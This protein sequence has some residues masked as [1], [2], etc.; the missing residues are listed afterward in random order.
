KQHHMTKFIFDEV[1]IEEIENP[2]KL[3]SSIKDLLN[4][5]ELLI[6]AP[7]Q[8]K[9][10]KI[11]KILTNPT[12]EQAS[13]LKNIR[14]FRFYKD[15]DEKKQLKQFLEIIRKPDNPLPELRSL[16]L[17]N[18]E[19]DC[20]LTLTKENVPTQITEL[21]FGN[22]YGTVKLSGL[23]QVKKVSTGTIV[24]E[25]I[26]ENLENLTEICIKNQQD[27]TPKN[28]KLVLTNLLKFKTLNI[29][30]FTNI[31]IHLEKIPNIKL[32]REH[33]CLY[34]KH[35]HGIKD[36]KFFFN[37]IINPDLRFLTNQIVH[38]NRLFD[39]LPPFRYKLLDTLTETDISNKAQQ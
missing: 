10:E 28:S 32:I 2:S 16:H 39:N 25:L 34:R 8:V 14:S 13:I 3:S 12:D 1:P 26:F 15:D 9:S 21:S 38:L 36:A 17:G 37:G 4:T 5:N 33:A 7:R 18:V 30:F 11:L 6:L 31:Q 24:G 29:D 35:V 23:S 19:R 22:I 20:N 27:W